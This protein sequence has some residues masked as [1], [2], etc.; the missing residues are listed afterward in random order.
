MEL[1][2]EVQRLGLIVGL[3]VTVADHVGARAR[4]FLLT[5]DLGAQ[6]LHECSIPRAGYEP[7]DLEGTQVVCAARL[8]NLCS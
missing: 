3:V 4:S 8:L 1:S 5:V 7:D 2:N 6:G